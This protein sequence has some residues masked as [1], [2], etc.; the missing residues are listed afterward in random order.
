MARNIS[1]TTS[2]SSS[3]ASAISPV[4]AQT[5]AQIVYFPSYVVKVLSHAPYAAQSDIVDETSYT[6][7]NARYS[8]DGRGWQGFESI[9]K[10]SKVLG[11]DLT[12]SYY[13]EFPLSGLV[14][15]VSS[16][17]KSSGSPL[18]ATTNTWSS[19]SENSGKNQ[20]LS[21][22]STKDTY[23]EG[24]S[25]TYSVDTAYANDAFGNI[26]TTTIQTDL[27]A[28]PLV[29]EAEYLNDTSSWVIGAKVSEKVVQSGATLKHT[30]YAYT[31]GSDSMSEQR[32]WIRDDVWSV[33]T[34]DKDAAGNDTVVHGP[35]QALREYA[36]DET[37][38]NC[39]RSTVYTSENATL[40]ESATYD[41]IHA[42]PISTTSPN[43]EI[44]SL[45]YDILGR[46]VETKLNGL[47][48]TKQQYSTNGADY[49][50]TEYALLDPGQATFY[51]TVSYIDGLGRTWKTERPAADDPSVTVISESHFDGAGRLVKRAR[52]YFSGS[53][54]TYATATYDAL[55]RVTQKTLPPPST[56]TSPLQVTYEYSFSSGVTKMV[57]SRSD[58]TQTE[59]SSHLIKGVPNPEP[60]SNNFVKNVA[61]EAIDELGQSVKTTFDGLARPTTITD[62][63]GVKLSLNYDGI[64]RVVERSI[65]HL[66][67]GSTKVI[68]HTTALFDDDIGSSTVTNQLTGSSIVTH[69]D[70][71]GRSTEKVTPEETFTFGY[72][73]GGD[74]T[75]GRLVS[76]SS[77]NGVKHLY[78]YD[79]HG[80]LSSDSL[81]IDGNT[82]TSN[83]LWTV[84]G[85]LTQ[86]TN[87]D[88]SVLQR[89]LLPD[90][91]SVSKIALVNA[92]SSLRA[93]VDLSSYDN[94]FSKPSTCTFGNGIV[95]T[96]TLSENGSVATMNLTKDS[97]VLHSQQWGIDSFSRIN[98][99]EVKADS[100]QGDNSFQYNAAG[101]ITKR[102]TGGLAAS[103][104][105]EDFTYDA[106]GN[107]NQKDG[108]S[109]MNTGWQL[110]EV[111]DDSGATQYTF[112]YSDDGNMTSKLDGAGNETRSMVYNSESRLIKLDRTSFLYDYKGRLIKATLS[113]G[114]V[115]LYPTLAYEVEFSPNGSKTETSYIVQGYRRASLTSSTSSSEVQYYH[116][117]HLGS[118]IA[119]S[120]DSGELITQYEYDTHGRA[121]LIKGDDV[122]RYKFSGKEQ[123]GDL[124]YYGA[125]FYDPEI[126]RFL[127]LDHYP[128][129]LEGIKPSTFNMY[130]FSRNDPI[131]YIDLNGNV[132]WWHWFVDV[133]LIVVGVA[134]T[135]A[136]GGALYNIVGSAFVGAGVS[137]LLYDVTAT[138]SG[139][140]S[141]K[142]WGIQLGIGALAGAISGG[143]SAA[144]DAMLPA[145][146]LGNIVS[147]AA[148]SGIAKSVASFAAR[149][150]NA[151]DGK[152]LGDG[153]ADAAARGAWQGAVGAGVDA[154]LSFFSKEATAIN[155]FWQKSGS[156]T[157]VEETT[158][159]SVANI[160]AEL[161]KASIDPSLGVALGMA[162][163]AI[164]QKK[165]QSA[166][167]PTAAQGSQA[168]A[169]NKSAAAPQFML[170]VQSSF[171]RF[172]PIENTSIL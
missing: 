3:S 25:K 119:V 168:A 105:A 12:T 112:K 78:D 69:F 127:T 103:D 167:A 43:G 160:V 28:T 95:A 1:F 109:M 66:V 143:A 9:T 32:Q 45:S 120:N 39:V 89:D 51:K 126:G 121:T 81:T 124:Y 17:E 151:I 41:L 117:D 50:K 144:L 165:D 100:H 37:Y 136:S 125:R 19:L 36:Y 171:P 161:S 47:V 156:Y 88:G 4:G 83:Y 29:I 54:P 93:T 107:L 159:R 106:S 145:A 61:V 86:A 99:H 16:V 115:R 8:Y 10:S 149:T 91:Q 157:L 84:A 68:N 74:F 135:V 56:S 80:N 101:Q 33:Q 140:S 49:L 34:V 137:G 142:D 163:W 13:Q 152:S 147:K 92:T 35:G 58:G 155:K 67:D 132:P 64:S 139:E 26:L 170:G 162:Q 97:N 104:S 22:S 85:G 141:D 31:P 23:Y 60:S 44:T 133:V 71:N 138:I 52:D 20:Y 108:L 94:V 130:A 59:A 166:Q 62:P 63:A 7:K 46:V 87:P 118:T 153:L 65:S 2:L 113:D 18:Q 6:Y 40:V 169:G 72:D 70:W 111:R 15:D 24:G 116:T 96:S 164:D 122:A 21:L 128:L 76:V 98:R 82:F 154:G 79:I 158:R 55:S 172:L 102:S 14:K 5:R 148:T 42:H 123:F 110:S 114:T 73:E 131:N 57:E 150:A 11:S 27:D 90:G 146:T 75:K 53:T 129:S 38:S 48:T 77:S 134:I 30:K